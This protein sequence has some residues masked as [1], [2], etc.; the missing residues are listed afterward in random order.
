MEK[1]AYITALR[2]GANE[3]VE[4]RRELEHG[5]N[6]GVA[7]AV[8]AVARAME[9][10]P[11][12]G[13]TALA[14]VAGQVLVELGRVVL[15]R[16]RAKLEGLP[17]SAARIQAAHRSTQVHS[18]APAMS[19]PPPGWAPVPGAL[20]TN[21]PGAAIY[22]VAHEEVARAAPHAGNE[23]VS[24][25]RSSTTAMIV[26]SSGASAAQPSSELDLGELLAW[27]A[28]ARVEESSAQS[29]KQFLEVAGVT[30]AL[31]VDALPLVTAAYLESVSA[32]VAGFAAQLAVEPVGF[33]HLERMNFTPAG[34]ERG[35]LLHSVPLAPGE[36]VNIAHKEWSNTSEEFQ[37]LVTDFLEAFSEEGVAEKSELAQA[38]ASQT[39]H[40][41]GLD[42][43]VT[44]S[45]GYGPVNVSASIS[46]NVADSAT[47]SQQ[48]SRNHSVALTRK[49]SSRV[50][51][52][53][54]ISFKVASASGTEDQ[55]VRR[56]K[57]PFDD[58]T[59]RIDYFQL[60]RK[61]KVDLF[62]YGLRLT[63]DLV[64]PEPGL[65]ILGRVQEINEI[66][67]ALDQGFNSGATTIKWARFD[68]EPRELTPSNYAALAAKYG[69]A[70][71][72]PPPEE[73]QASAAETRVWSRD[74]AK[75]NQY[76]TL[77]IDVDD[78]YLVERVHVEASRS[79]YTG[80][81]PEFW[82]PD[83]S[84]FVG[85]SGKLTLVYSAKSL[86]SAFV[87]ID[88]VLRLTD[89]AMME[90]RM[91]AWGAL[92]D[93]AL[94]RYYENRQMLKER[95]DY[96]STEIGATDALS[97]RKIEREEVMKCTM[98]WLFGPA[99]AY[100]VPGVP[101]NSFDDGQMVSPI[102][103]ALMQQHGEVIKFIHQAIEWENMLFF[104]YPYFWSHVSRWG[105]KK[106]LSHPDSTHRAFLKAGSARVVLTIRPGF[107]R[108][109]ASFIETGTL[110]PLAP[111]HPYLR[112]AEEMEAYANTNYPGIAAANPTSTDS[113]AED[114][115]PGQGLKIG[116]WYEY[117]PTSALDIGFDTSL[118]SG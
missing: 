39:Q 1:F 19:P 86:S 65:G 100:A 20:V 22:R 23:D 110:D 31:R 99:F 102:V 74:E 56:I 72:P 92:R 17:A 106:F 54:K 6:P 57:N 88:A 69:V 52:E 15:Q 46:R 59:T 109:F 94:A 49:A 115:S 104:L 87:K 85:K 61:W 114:D 60:V 91:K 63:Y 4:L 77:E 70:L 68:L 67:A 28:S 50:K 16:R 12:S 107:E 42:M 78:D 103:F 47:K 18:A 62:R 55:A 29:L 101:A 34:I 75:H 118:P 90:W 83:A 105:E 33:L 93:A 36:E 112:I 24:T 11:I 40:T 53:H 111:D 89:A 5:G 38:S 64:V 10:G 97:L 82:V 32:V 98:R 7:A 48:F 45:G 108:A 79:F 8:N 25:S 43:S 30:S 41:S 66:R 80:T 81:T 44:A 3:V 96:L 21:M 9:S 51:K 117:V 26:R 27:A 73:K 13:A 76:Y 58:R 37:K 71:S 116:T 2:L 95:L 113:P 35:E 14:P 84:D